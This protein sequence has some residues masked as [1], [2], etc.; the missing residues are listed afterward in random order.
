MTNDSSTGGYL[1]PSIS[2]LPVL[3]DAELYSFFQAIFVGLTGID[4][5]LVRP[6][7]QPVPPNQPAANVSWMAFGITDY[8]SDTFSYEIHSGSLNGGQ[9][10]SYIGD[11]E[12]ITILCSFYGPSAGA[13]ASLVRDGLQ[14]G[15]N[16]EALT[17]AGMTLV[18]S[19]KRTAVPQLTNE[20]WINRIDLPVR[21]RRSEVRIYPIL[22][23]LTAT[24]TITIDTGVTSQFNAS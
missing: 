15:Q 18:D 20:Q 19:G 10:G 1:L 9:G 5:K 16:R 4:G 8:D 23:L 24:G 11:N 12:I 17:I 7:W 3:E 13:N 14:V 22:N 2:S 21:I 6:R